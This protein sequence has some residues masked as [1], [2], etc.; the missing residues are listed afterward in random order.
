MYLHFI[1][2]KVQLKLNKIDY[3]LIIQGITEN[4]EKRISKIDRQRIEGVVYL[5]LQKEVEK[6]RKELQ[7]IVKE[8]FK[9]LRQKLSDLIEGEV[10]IQLK[11]IHLPP[12]DKKWNKNKECRTEKKLIY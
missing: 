4:L 11:P 9:I 1:D 8:E 5:E 10:K 12:K 7:N 3:Q 2:T 6:I